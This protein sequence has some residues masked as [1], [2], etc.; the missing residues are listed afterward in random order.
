MFLLVK[1]VCVV[2]LYLDLLV[3]M[4]FGINR[5]LYDEVPLFEEAVVLEIGWSV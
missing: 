4:V 2:C 3:L 5:L 1:M